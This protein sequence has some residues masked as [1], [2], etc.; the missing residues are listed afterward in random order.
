MQRCCPF[1]RLLFPCSSRGR[2]RRLIPSIITIGLLLFQDE[3]HGDSL[4]AACC[5]NA[6]R[7]AIDLQINQVGRQILRPTYS[8]MKVHQA[9]WCPQRR[10]TPLVGRNTM[11]IAD[12]YMPPGQR[13]ALDICQKWQ[14]RSWRAWPFC[15][16]RETSFF[17]VGR[18]F[19]VTGSKD[20]C[21]HT[22]ISP[23][24]ERFNL[25]WIIL[26]R[27]DIIFLFTSNQQEARCMTDSPKKMPK[28]HHVLEMLLVLQE[29]PGIHPLWIR[30]CPTIFTDLNS[31]D[32]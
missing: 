12:V 11:S 23:E 6:F 10:G 21:Y 28:T 18:Q 27:Q 20:V 9:D 8:L 30:E 16:S 17:Q 29:R 14:G 26:T 25:A 5:Q 13:V 3:C 15:F 7:V 32:A 2:R 31:G 22:S 1:T 19:S 24:R 4:Q